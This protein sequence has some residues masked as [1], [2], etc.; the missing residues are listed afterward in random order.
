MP[1]VLEIINIAKVSQYLAANDIHKKQFGKDTLDS[2]LDIKL[3]MVRKAVQ[4]K[5]GKDP[6]NTTDLIQTSN[7][8]YALCGP[9]APE[10]ALII[11]GGTGGTVI[12]GQ[13]VEESDGGGAFEGDL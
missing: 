6:S 10:A 8:L 5:Y 3:Y 11:S 9:Y 1:T 13:P 2:R 4:W 12:G 7:Y